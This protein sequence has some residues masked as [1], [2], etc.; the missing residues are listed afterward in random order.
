MN[1]LLYVFA[2]IICNDS[3]DNVQMR[4]RN[5]DLRAIFEKYVRF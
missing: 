4:E 3:L 1:S 5:G 2:S